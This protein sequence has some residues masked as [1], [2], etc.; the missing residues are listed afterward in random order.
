MSL[1]VVTGDKGFASDI[2]DL[3]AER[4]LLGALMCNGKAFVSVSDMLTPEMF[5]HEAH[6]EVFRA[7]L[8]LH[9]AGQDPCD[10]VLLASAMYRH[11][12]GQ[13][14]DV[15]ALLG[16]VMAAEFMTLNVMHYAE[17]VASLAH[18]RELVARAG[19]VIATITRD[20]EMTPNEAQDYAEASIRSAGGSVL[21]EC[22]PSIADLMAQYHQSKDAD[23]QHRVPTG[24]RDLDEMTGSGLGQ[25]W[26]TVVLASPGHG[27]TALA[28][29]VSAHAAEQ[30]TGVAFY[31]LEM[32]SAEVIDRLLYAH[33]GREKAHSDPTQLARVADWP[34][35][36]EDFSRIGL[37]PSIENIR[38]DARRV[39][40][41]MQRNGNRLG[42]VVV[43]RLALVAKSLRGDRNNEEQ[44]AHVC[45]SLKR[46]AIELGV[47]VM[48]LCQPTL[49][50]RRRTAAHRPGQT[51]GRLSL[52]D[53]KGSGAMQAVAD[54]ALLPYRENPKSE[55]DGVAEVIV[56]K[57]RHGQPTDIKGLKWCSDRLTYT[58]GLVFS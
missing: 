32:T 19:D 20:T 22:A 58:D 17:I 12:V 35:H 37:T 45:S 18:K 49:D 3:R 28:V 48:L 38:V 10:V 54:L 52:S 40:Q 16:S 14:F 55:G 23:T 41:R 25:G 5:Y 43:D 7:Q 57:Y 27:K 21:G 46:L 9:R 42:L 30:G 11:G 33:C 6:C 36:L 34:L 51:A 8:E 13:Q 26:V 4:A 53:A 56:G 47:S 2:K 29:G 1:A 24:I 31:S 44:L 15:E 39:A 50:S